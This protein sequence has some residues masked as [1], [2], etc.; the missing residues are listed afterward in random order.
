MQ[1]LV[2]VAS[3]IPEILRGPEILNVGHVTRMTFPLS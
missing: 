1:N 2:L 3:A